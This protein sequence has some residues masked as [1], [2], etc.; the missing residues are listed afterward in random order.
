MIQYPVVTSCTYATQYHFAQIS[1]ACDQTK[2]SDHNK[3]QLSLTTFTTFPSLPFFHQILPSSSLQDARQTQRGK[4]YVLVPAGTPCRSVPCAA[5]A[6]LPSWSKISHGLTDNFFYFPQNKR[7]TKRMGSLGL[8]RPSLPGPRL[9]NRRMMKQSPASVLECSLSV[10]S[11]VHI[12]HLFLCPSTSTD[13]PLYHLWT[14][15]LSID[16]P[17]AWNRF[18]TRTCVTP[19]SR[20]PGGD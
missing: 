18:R 7:S 1:T 16:H 14:P 8:S 11:Q 4:K 15:T 19:R 3:S 17:T 12:S 13:L 2:R 20:D 6:P 9:P 10:S 5:I